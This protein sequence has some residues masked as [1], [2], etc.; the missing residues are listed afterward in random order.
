M[1]TTRPSV[2]CHCLIHHT[3]TEKEREQAREALRYARSIGD[4]TGIMMAVAALQK[5]PSV[6][7][8]PVWKVEAHSDGSC[9]FYVVSDDVSPGEENWFGGPYSEAEAI[10]E[11][12]RRNGKEANGG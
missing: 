1:D 3:I 11:A 2:Q 12:A 10:T 4:S 5:C 7:K 8:A 9:I 6:P